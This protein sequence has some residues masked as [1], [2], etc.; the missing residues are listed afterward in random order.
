MTVFTALSNLDVLGYHAAIMDWGT[1]SEMVDN[2]NGR[3]KMKLPA[4]RAE[5]LGQLSL[6]PFWPYLC[7]WQNQSQLAAYNLISNDCYPHIKPATLDC[8]FEAYDLKSKV[9][10]K[11][12]PKYIYQF[13]F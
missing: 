4:E 3:S 11:R 2:R 10:G 13:S 5:K 9:G 1:W 12:V 6:R 7:G 8:V